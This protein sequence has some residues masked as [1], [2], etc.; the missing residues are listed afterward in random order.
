[1]HSIKT[2]YAEL[3]ESEEKAGEPFDLDAY[4][5]R[6][7]GKGHEAIDLEAI[8]DEEELKESGLLVEKPMEKGSS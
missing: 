6:Y 5:L 2:H 4:R 8:T 7:K 1:M 3:A